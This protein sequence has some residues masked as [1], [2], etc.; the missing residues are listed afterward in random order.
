LLR[1]DFATEVAAFEVRENAEFR[2]PVT[3][4]W[5]SNSKTFGCEEEK[6]ACELLDE[7]SCDWDIEFDR[8]GLAA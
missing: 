8:L 6:L 5:F 2:C 3:R 1:A 7:E 4:Q